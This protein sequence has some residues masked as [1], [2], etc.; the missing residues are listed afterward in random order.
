MTLHT[1]AVHGLMA[2]HAHAHRH[3]WCPSYPACLRTCNTGSGSPHCPLAAIGRIQGRWHLLGHMYAIVVLHP[4]SLLR[5][6]SKCPPARHLRCA[7]WVSVELYTRNAF[8][9]LVSLGSRTGP[10]L[11][12]WVNAPLHIT[13]ALPS[14]IEAIASHTSLHASP[15]RWRRQGPCH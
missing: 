4:P 8:S 12:Y 3:T 13:D 11:G 5:V 10:R 2:Q 15:S 7:S 14:C 9:S 1:G 6:G